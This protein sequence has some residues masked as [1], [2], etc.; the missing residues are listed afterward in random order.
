MLKEKIKK[1][2]NA[3]G[4]VTG[5]VRQAHHLISRAQN[6]LSHNVIQQAA[7]HFPP[8]HIDEAL[9]SIAVAAWRNQPNHS[10]YNN[11]IKDKLDIFKELN[12]NASLDDSYNFVTNLI[13]DIRNWV[14]N[15]PN[16]H[17]NDL[18]LP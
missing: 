8:F 3:I 1:F 11:L 5:D 13:S 18:I 9:N 14:I 17:L 15:N 4:L 6:I 7:K 12:P 10:A 2:R 16:A